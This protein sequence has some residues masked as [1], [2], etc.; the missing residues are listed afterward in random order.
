MNFEDHFS[1]LAETYAQFRPR[2]PQ[3]LYAYLSEQTPDHHLAWD[4]ATGSGQAAL[5]LAQHF[6][7]VA[8]VDA[9]LGQLRQAAAHP[10]VRYMA[11]RAEHIPLETGCTD[12]V[13]AAMAVHWFDFDIFYQEVRRVLRPGGSFLSTTW[14]PLDCA[15]AAASSETSRPTACHPTT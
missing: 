11:A 5:G 4:C 14:A 1:Q 6:K 7:R 13:T 9:G 12:L 2:Y 3:Q 8:A 10:R 15:K